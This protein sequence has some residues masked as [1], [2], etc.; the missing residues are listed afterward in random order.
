LFPCPTSPLVE[1]REITQGAALMKKQT[2][3]SN[4]RV[5]FNGCDVSSSGTLFANPAQSSIQLGIV[6]NI[7]LITGTS[8]G[9]ARIFDATDAN[10]R[11]A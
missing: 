2:N 3:A 10:G 9:I 8:W 4:P 7:L 11:A 5:R 6:R 1:C